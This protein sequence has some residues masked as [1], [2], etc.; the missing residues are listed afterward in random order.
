MEPISDDLRDLID[1]FRSHGVEFLVVG[2]RALAF[3]GYPRNTYDLDLWVRRSAESAKRIRAA[4]AD[5]G[6]QIG[7][8]GER[9]FTLQRNMLVLGIPP[10]QV[11]VLTFLDGCD[12]DEAW[13]RRISGELNDVAVSFLSVEDYVLTKKASGRDKDLRDL[14]E[15]RRVLG[16]LPGDEP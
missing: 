12:F 8:E 1:S 6:I 14:G 15:L 10:N 4:L 9:Q 2:A 5:F 11:D 16:K 3:Y 7:D 13:N